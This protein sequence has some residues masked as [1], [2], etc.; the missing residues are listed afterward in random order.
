MLRHILF[1][2]R[3]FET[4]D[5]RKRSQKGLLWLLEA[6]AQWNEIY[7]RAH[8]ETP[9][10][11]QSGV[12]YKLPEQ[13]DRQEVPEIGRLREIV[14]QFAD[15]GE[16]QEALELLKRLADQLGGGEHFRDI[17]AVLENGGGDC[18]PIQARLLRRAPD[19]SVSDVEAG[20]V[21]RGDH[22]W[23]RGRWSRVVATAAKGVLPLDRIT[24]EA[25]GLHAEPRHVLLTR[26][27]EV[28]VVETSGAVR[29]ITVG[30]I[31]SGMGMIRPFRPTMFPMPQSSSEFAWLPLDPHTEQCVRATS[32]ER[33]FAEAPCVDFQTDDHYV[34][35]VNG[36]VIVSQCDNLAAFRVGELR[37]HDIFAK[38]YITWRRRPDNGMTYHA[39][40]LWPDGSSEDPSLL[41][42]MGGDAKESE[43]EKEREKLAERER[44]RRRGRGLGRVIA[45]LLAPPIP[46]VS[47]PTSLDGEFEAAADRF[48]AR[49][50]R[51]ETV[52]GDSGLGP[53]FGQGVYYQ[54]VYWSDDTYEDFRPGPPTAFYDDIRLPGVVTP[55]P[56]ARPGLWQ[57]G[58]S[59][60]DREDN[61]DDDLWGDAPPFR[62]VYRSGMRT[63]VA[64]TLPRR[65]RGY[66]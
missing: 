53:G 44:R 27:H 55:G 35:L 22:V 10:L 11:Y 16:R 29:R 49:R 25:R 1:D 15:R 5:G 66:R 60:F 64:R 43:R 46:D 48:R 8:P 33:G 24:I 20:N 40:V 32:V 45:R 58:G 7:L 47:E 26:D 3:L 62:P 52:L 63:F 14:M 50:L 12:I 38:P 57:E 21:Q 13:F 28:F 4:E 6:L 31:E 17:Q 39:I 34:Y 65:G 19:G 59:R 41:L 23:G 30:Q 61:E 37:A 9:R 18:F 36:D 42:G 54:P 2:V 56:F 51:A